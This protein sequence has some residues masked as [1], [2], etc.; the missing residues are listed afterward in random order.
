MQVVFES[1]IARE[2]TERLEAIVARSVADYRLPADVRVYVSRQRNG[3][4]VFVTGLEVHPLPVAEQI[5]AALFREAP[6]RCS[7]HPV[8]RPRGRRL[9]QSSS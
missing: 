7:R 4:S 1:A 5:R 2:A 9:D 3:W 8:T 6:E